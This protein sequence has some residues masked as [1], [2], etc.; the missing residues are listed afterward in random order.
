[1]LEK[2][3]PIAEKHGV[4]VG[5]LVIAWTAA[6]YDKMHVLCGARNAKQVQENA[7]AGDVRLTAD[8]VAERGQIVAASA[9]A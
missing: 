3:Q 5:Q 4:N 9:V 6:F 2:F 1:M 7:K 8:E